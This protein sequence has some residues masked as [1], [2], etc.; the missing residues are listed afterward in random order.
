MEQAAEFHGRVLLHRWQGVRID[1]QGDLDPLVPQPFRHD[2]NRHA[3]LKQERG[4]RVA[5]SME[6]DPF[7]LGLRMVFHFCTRF[8]RPVRGSTFRPTSRTIVQ[9]PG[10]R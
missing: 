3:S 5:D 10:Y 6:G 1:I 2:F 7:D 9:L 4:A 8:V